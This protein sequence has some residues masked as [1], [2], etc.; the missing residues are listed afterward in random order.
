MASYKDMVRIRNEYMNSSSL[1]DHEFNLI[2]GKV[3]G[4]HFNPVDAEETSDNNLTQ[5]VRLLNQRMAGEPIQYILGTWPFLDIELIVDERALIPRPET[6]LLALETIKR[7]LIFQNSTII[8]LCSGSGAIAFAIEDKVAGSDIIAV[9][10]SSKACSLINDNK[11]R[12][13]SNVKVVEEDVFSY[14]PSLEDSSCDIFVCNPPYVT[15]AEYKS[16]YEELK[17]EPRDAF[18]ASENGCYFYNRLTPLCFPKLRPGGFLLY[19]IGDEQKKA[20]QEIMVKWGYDNI[21][22][23]K[24]N[25]GHDRVIIG[26][27]PY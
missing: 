13:K 26:K 4:N 10:Y 14:I 8:D 19:E 24:D 20:V 27:K 23:M 1:S 16:N 6:E 17:Y 7:S 15:E 9:E 21:Q 12:L 2:Y 18:I 3:T 22:T 11:A 5:I 25:E